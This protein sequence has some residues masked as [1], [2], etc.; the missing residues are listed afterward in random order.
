ME[1]FIFDFDDKLWEVFEKVRYW[2]FFFKECRKKRVMK[3]F[4][5]MFK[6]WENL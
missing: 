3:F 2:S 6:D 1:G 5:F 4:G